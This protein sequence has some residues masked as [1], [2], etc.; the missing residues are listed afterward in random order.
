M[1]RP[2]QI[3]EA[4]KTLADEAAREVAELRSRR[5]TM[6]R[7]QVDKLL[8]IEQGFNDARRDRTASAAASGFAKRAL[9]EAKALGWEVERI[10]QE[11]VKARDLLVERFADQKR[12][13]VYL[14]QRQIKAKAVA[15]KREERLLLEQ[16]NQL[17]QQRAR[18][19]EVK[20]D[21]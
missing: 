21:D 2:E 19:A 10:A 18:Q 4:F 13:E 3:R 12:F 5:D 9:L 14:S 1:K 15:R 6:L 20:D 11:E 8:S 17:A 16:I 7:A